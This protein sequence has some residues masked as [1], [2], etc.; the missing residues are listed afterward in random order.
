MK[1]L[2]FSTIKKTIVEV[3]GPTFTEIVGGTMSKKPASGV[4]KILE[5]KLRS[6][7]EKVI[8]LYILSIFNLIFMYII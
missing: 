4:K 7:D 2:C 1:Y 6:P 3:K 5:K 8:L